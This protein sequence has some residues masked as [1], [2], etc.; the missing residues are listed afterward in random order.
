MLSLVKD[1]Q[2]FMYNHCTSLE[3]EEFDK[4]KHNILNHERAQEL[5]TLRV[6]RP[7]VYYMGQE[8]HP[9]I[10]KF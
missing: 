3:V 9:M 1:I 2:I 7:L 5:N 4:L 8:E 6:G 10:I